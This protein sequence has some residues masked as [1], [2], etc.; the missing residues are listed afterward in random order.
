MGNG[1]AVRAPSNRDVGFAKPPKNQTWRIGHVQRRVK[2]GFIASAGKPVTT[3]ELI[4]RAYPRQTKF[5]SWQYAQVRQA[6]ERWAKRI[7]TVGR[8]GA[9]LWA[10]YTQHGRDMK[11]NCQ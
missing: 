8:G 11:N 7:G 4:R 5:E 10:P 3:G 6:A 1:I 9:I 2:R